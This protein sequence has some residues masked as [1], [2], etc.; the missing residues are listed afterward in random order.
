MCPLSCFRKP[1]YDMSLSF[2]LLLVYNEFA[3]E[4]DAVCMSFPTV[5][6][7]VCMSFPTVCYAVCMSFPTVCYAVCMSFPMEYDACL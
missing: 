7:A 5:C 6:Y 1:A 4:C 3:M 2:W